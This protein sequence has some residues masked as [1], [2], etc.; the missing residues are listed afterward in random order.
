MDTEEKNINLGG[1][2][3][4]YKISDELKKK[5]EFNNSIEGEKIKEE[6]INLGYFPPSYKHSYELK[7][8]R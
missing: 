7:K 2:P 6:D 4:N 8:K 3:P 5:R 1:F